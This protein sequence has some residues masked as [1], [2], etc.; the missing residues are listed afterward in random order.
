MQVKE[1]NW[2]ELEG[3][4][5]NIQHDPG[6]PPEV[7]AQIPDSGIVKVTNPVIFH[8]VGRVCQ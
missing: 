8:S 2:W 5:L 6:N 7:A 1:P 3:V 4:Q